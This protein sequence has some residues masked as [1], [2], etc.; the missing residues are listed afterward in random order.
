[1]ATA[2]APKP[3]AEHFVFHDIGWDGYRTLTKLLENRRVRSTYDR[4]NYEIMS[5]L[6]S[7]KRFGNRLGRMIEAITV[8][9][10]IPM[11][12][13]GATTF[14]SEELDRGL[15]PDECYYFENA[16]RL[17]DPHDI[18]LG[19][20]PPPDL[21]I[22]VE[23][24]RTVLDRL[25]VYAALGVPEVWRFDGER[26]I[27]LLLQADGAYAERP[28][29][30]CLPFLSLEEIARFARDLDEPNDTRWARS[31]RHWVREHLV[32]RYEQWRADRGI[33]E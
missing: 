33:G 19:R 14:K 18:D 13:V 29:S 7:H 4:G 22:E 30:A 9:L 5:P 25:G 15:E 16:I 28:T 1:M 12:G 31:F 11:V 17:V 23:V 21:A 32:P 24:T 20:D 3:L 10:D 6:C 26:L 2:T 8:E 27:I